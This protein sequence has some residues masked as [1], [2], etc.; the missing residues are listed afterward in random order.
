MAVKPKDTGGTGR[1]QGKTIRGDHIHTA[2]E[3]I[4]VAREGGEKERYR[5]GG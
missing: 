1:G 3:I 2:D 4:T 5:R